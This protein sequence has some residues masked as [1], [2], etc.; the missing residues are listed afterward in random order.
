MTITQSASPHSGKTIARIN[1]NII[2]SRSESPTHTGHTHTRM[3]TRAC[4]QDSDRCTIGTSRQ[5]WLCSAAME[6]QG[7]ARSR[8]TKWL[9][10]RSGRF[11]D[12]VFVCWRV[13]ETQKSALK[14][15]LQW[16]DQHAGDFSLPQH[17]GK[18]IPSQIQIC[19]SVYT[20]Q[21]VVK[22]QNPFLPVRL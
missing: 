16:L 17:R 3:H 20:K 5:D 10:T 19:L 1:R 13:E 15:R 8:C 9:G 14:H 7:S 21:K 12:E 18:F 6:Q 2:R 4:S 22:L 11:V